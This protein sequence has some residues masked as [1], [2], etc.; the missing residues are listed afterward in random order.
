[1][2]TSTKASKQLRKFRRYA[3]LDIFYAISFEC[4]P[5]LACTVWSLPAS[6]ETQ[7]RNSKIR[8]IFAV[9]V[10]RIHISARLWVPADARDRCHEPISASPPDSESYCCWIQEMFAVE[11]LFYFIHYF[12]TKICHWFCLGEYLDGEDARNQKIDRCSV[13]F[14]DHYTVGGS[15]CV[16]V[17]VCVCV[18]VCVRVCVCVCACVC[19]CVYSSETTTQSEACFSIESAQSLSW[20]DQ[21]HGYASVKYTLNAQVNIWNEMSSAQ[22][23]QNRFRGNQQNKDCP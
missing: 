21:I 2:D 17:C 20:I 10:H 3:C 12:E 11:A 5:C 7:S 1:M 22:F 16:R 19:V 18:C 23:M 4:A 13:F 15:V 9:S 6:K 14:R 8:Q